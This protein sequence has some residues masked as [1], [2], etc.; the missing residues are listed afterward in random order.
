MQQI[1]VTLHMSKL[2]ILVVHPNFSRIRQSL[3][4]QTTVCKDAVTNAVKPLTSHESRQSACPDSTRALK[5]LF[6]RKPG[7]FWD[8]VLHTETI[9][10][11]SY[12]LSGITNIKF[13]FVDLSG[14][15]R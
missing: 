3:L 12:E 9:D 10:L 2:H 11:S 14:E 13:E 7:R 1:W 6:Q 4:N 15:M 5:K 8:N